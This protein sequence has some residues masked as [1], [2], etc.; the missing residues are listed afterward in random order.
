MLVVASTVGSIWATDTF[1]HALGSTMTI[2]GPAEP[3]GGLKRASRLS[4][5]TSPADVIPTD[6]Q[7]ILDA[8]NQHRAAHGIAPLEL[9][10]QLAEAAEIHALDHQVRECAAELS[11]TGTDGSGPGD[12]IARTGLRVRTW[13]ENIACGYRTAP[14]VMQGWIDSPGHLANI[15]NPAFT[16]LGVATSFGKDGNPY[17]GQVFGTPR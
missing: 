12:R 4:P 16:H 8:T 15:L 13:G 2:V 11:H 10:P 14:S 9:H 7:T 3:E 1:T 5:P 17:W 6:V